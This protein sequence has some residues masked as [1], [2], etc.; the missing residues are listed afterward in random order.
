[1]RRKWVTVCWH[2]GWPKREG[3]SKEALACNPKRTP[4]PR[5]KR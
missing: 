1:M 3:H 4:K 2:C 5:R